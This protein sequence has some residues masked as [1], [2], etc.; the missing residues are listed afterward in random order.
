MAF[1]MGQLRRNWKI[2][3]L[4]VFN[5]LALAFFAPLRNF[6][7]QRI[8]DAKAISTLLRS[9]VVVLA[10]C[11]FVFLLESLSNVSQASAIRNISHNLRRE[12]YNQVISNNLVSFRNNTT[13]EYINTLTTDIKIIADDCFTPIFEVIL[14]SGFI[15]VSIIMLAS[16]HV[17]LLGIVLVQSVIIIVLPRLIGGRLQKLRAAYSERMGHYIARIKDFFTG[18]E[19]I[20]TFHIEEKVKE[21][22]E[23]INEALSNIEYKF[24]RMNLLGQSATS[25]INYIFFVF[26]TG[27]S[28]VF[29]LRGHIT[30]GQMIAATQMMIF[31]T[32]P[33]AIISRNLIRIKSTMDIVSKVESIMKAKPAEDGSVDVEKLDSAITLDGVSYSYD[34]VTNV[35]Q[36][37]SCIFEKGKKYAVVGTS[38]SGKST[39]IKL[40]LKYYGEYSGSIQFD[41]T[42]IKH[43][44]S[45]SFTNLCQT[46]P[47]SVFLF[48]DTV[49]NNICLY[50]EYTSD[51]IAEAVHKSGLA[52]VID[53]T[54]S[55]LKRWLEK[56]VEISPVVKSKGWPLP[57]L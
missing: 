22:H 57:E 54:T 7:I 17:G 6:L 43:I 25:F 30:F 23:E 4:L 12:V 46:I 14:Y 45:E 33:A 53:G 15:L 49:R 37:I 18:F 44:S 2:I 9:V 56:M 16:V 40:I 11:L 10:L 55:A 34:G 52:Q 28:M 13:S 3:L 5:L 35:L 47:Q 27:S 21:E 29:L 24:S 31:I 32:T 51:E 50:E 38:G 8:I 26:I 36:D 42:E 39:L 41:D 48:N 1:I 19:V 20:K